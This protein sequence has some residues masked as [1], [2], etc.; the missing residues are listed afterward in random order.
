M[1]WL[2]GFSRKNHAAWPPVLQPTTLALYVHPLT[3]PPIGHFVF[4]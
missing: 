1:G 3:A 4:I 2:Q